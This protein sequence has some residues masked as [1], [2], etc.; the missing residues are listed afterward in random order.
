VLP[1][2]FWGT[3][4]WGSIKCEKMVVEGLII[5]RTIEMDVKIIITDLFP[6][7]KKQSTCTHRHV[8]LFVDV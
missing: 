3:G 5:K 1:D 8:A 4:G 6:N 7:L 2:V